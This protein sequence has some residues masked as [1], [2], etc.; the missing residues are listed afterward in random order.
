MGRVAEINAY[1][2]NVIVQ[3]GLVGT[4][5]GLQLRATDGIGKPAGLLA[6]EVAELRDELS[7]W[8]RMRGRE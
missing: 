1:D 6:P 5:P 8:L 2:G 7:E 4:Q 3:D